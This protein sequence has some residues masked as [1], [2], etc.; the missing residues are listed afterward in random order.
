[1]DITIDTV[2]PQHLFR[3]EVAEQI[4]TQNRNDDEDGWTYTVVH[5][6]SG[7]SCVVI[8]DEDGAEVGKL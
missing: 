4:A 6:E 5:F 3:P 7:W 2:N 8:H 1:M